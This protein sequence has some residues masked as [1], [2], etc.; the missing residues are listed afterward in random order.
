M[1][2]ILNRKCSCPS[3]V[4]FSDSFPPR[5]SLDEGKDYPFCRRKFCLQNFMQAR[6]SHE[7]AEHF[8]EFFR[9][10]NEQGQGLKKRAEFKL[11]S[12]GALR[13]SP[14]RACLKTAIR[15]GLPKGKARGFAHSTCCACLMAT[16]Q[17]FPANIGFFALFSFSG[18]AKKGESKGNGGTTEQAKPDRRG[19]QEALRT[20][21]AALA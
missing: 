20:L 2:K 11:T 13:H 18:K 17:G 21:L 3:S 4:A 6:G 9:K 5:G 19:K 7:V 1:F 16:Q 12:L 10:K 14:C 15:Q 8:C